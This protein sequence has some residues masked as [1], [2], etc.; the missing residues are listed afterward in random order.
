VPNIL[1]KDLEQMVPDEHDEIFEMSEKL[2]FEWIS[3]YL[4]EADRVEGF[5]K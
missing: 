5:Y 3:L 2:A 1:K 4:Q